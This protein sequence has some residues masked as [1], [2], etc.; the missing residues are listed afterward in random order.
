MPKNMPPI[1]KF[2]ESLVFQ[3]FFYFLQ[4][5][6]ILLIEESDADLKREGGVSE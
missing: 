6:D 3:A 5:S 4:T 1:N 2:F